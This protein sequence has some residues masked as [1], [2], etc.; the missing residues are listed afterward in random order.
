MRAFLW[1]V[2]ALIACNGGLMSRAQAQDS[3][4]VY[5]TRYG[6]VVVAAATGSW[7][8]LTSDD[9]YDP[10]TGTALA[11]GLYLQEVS[12]VS[13]ETAG[14]GDNA[15]LC[16]GASAGCGA[17]THAPRIV[18]GGARVWSTRGLVAGGVTAQA[19]SLR[20]VGSGTADLEVCGTY[21]TQ[22]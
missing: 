19:V 18:A 16:M 7:G 12:V 11:A 21:R 22:P 6:C 5:G 15:V 1:W 20:S 4:G 8:E 17:T 14:T 13:R 2:I 3:Q 9:L 10:A